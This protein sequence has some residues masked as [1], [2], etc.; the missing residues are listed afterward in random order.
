MIAG[1]VRIKLGAWY[2][3]G[4]MVY[5]GGEGLNMGIPEHGMEL[6]SIAWG[7]E[8]QN[9]GGMIMAPE[10][11]VRSMAWGLRAWKSTRKKLV[12]GNSMAALEQLRHRPS[13]KQHEQCKPCSL[14][15]APTWA[16]QPCAADST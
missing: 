8:A 15:R 11:G 3:S 6:K 16:Q 13:E 4:V 14:C 7:W 2:A 10:R 9:R 5:N 12:L 1:K